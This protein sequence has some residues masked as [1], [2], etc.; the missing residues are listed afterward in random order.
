[1]YLLRKSTRS[2]FARPA[3]QC[4]AP[5]RVL[6][7]VVAYI[8]ST[9]AVKSPFLVLAGQEGLEPPTSGFGDRRSTNW[10][11]WPVPAVAVAVATASH[12]SRAGRTLTTNTVALAGLLMQRMPFVPLAVL[13]EFNALRVVLL[14]LFRRIVSTLTFRAS[15]RN[16]RSHLNSTS[17]QRGHEPPIRSGMGGS[18]SLL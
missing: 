13:L 18:G 16:Q 4:V 14:I 9:F 7:P 10:S 2:R 11:Y 3:T 1:M 17:F 15:E 5:S 6:V 8:H 12:P